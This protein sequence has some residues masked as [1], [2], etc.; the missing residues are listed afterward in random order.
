MGEREPGGT[1]RLR[2]VPVGED[3][4]KG[5]GIKGS[6]TSLRYERLGEEERGSFLL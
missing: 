3:L 2:G 5:L 6:K 1:E 4:G